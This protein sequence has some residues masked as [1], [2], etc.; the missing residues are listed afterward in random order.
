MEKEQM[1]SNTKDQMDDDQ[2]K[3]ETGFIFNDPLSPTDMGS[4]TKER[5]S[6]FKTQIESGSSMKEQMYDDMCSSTKDQ[7]YDNQSQA[8]AGFVTKDKMYD[9]KA[10]A[11]VGKSTLPASQCMPESGNTAKQI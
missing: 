10:D 1:G 6:D 7:M 3:A 2:S 11:D 8:E 9:D 5:M 4:S